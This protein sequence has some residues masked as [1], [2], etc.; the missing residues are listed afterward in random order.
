MSQPHPPLPPCETLTVHAS[1]VAYEGRAVLITGASGTGKSGLALQLMAL[2]AEL[3]SDDCT[4]LTRD[5]ESLIASAPEAIQGQIE[6]RFV[7]ILKAPAT[8]PTALALLVNLDTI[9]S[10]RLPPLRTEPLM[11]ILFPSVHKSEGSHFPAAILQYLKQG[12]I[13]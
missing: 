3:V 13:A 6:A 11:G 8:A 1:T 5:G 4:I 12:R 10:E 7:G 9:E 2:G